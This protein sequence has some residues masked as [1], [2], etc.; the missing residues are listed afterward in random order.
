MY[1]RVFRYARCL[2]GDERTAD[3]LAVES[4]KWF[5]RRMDDGDLKACTPL[6]PYIAK[7]CKNH[8][9]NRVNQQKRRREDSLEAIVDELPYIADPTPSEDAWISEIQMACLLDSFSPEDAEIIRLLTTG[10]RPA[11]IER[12]MGLSHGGLQHRIKRKLLPRLRVLATALGLLEGD[13]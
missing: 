2:V 13:V 1:P 5:W 8:N 9:K 4:L 6:F 7:I 10:H 11:D 3:E 12:T